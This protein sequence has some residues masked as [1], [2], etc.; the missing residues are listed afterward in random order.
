MPLT[1]S[2]PLQEG[3]PSLRFPGNA[4]SRQSEATR[5][6]GAAPPIAASEHPPSLPSPAGSGRF[7]AALRRLPLNR[8][9]PPEELARPPL[10]AFPPSRPKPWSR[11]DRL[12]PAPPRGQLASTP[13]DKKNFMTFSEPRKQKFHQ[14]FRPFPCGFLAQ[15]PIPNCN[16]TYGSLGHN[17]S[18]TCPQ[19]LEKRPTTPFSRF[20]RER[21]SKSSLDRFGCFKFRFFLPGPLTRNCRFRFQTQ[22]RYETESEKHCGIDIED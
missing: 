14:K 3:R 18:T 21:L 13:W 17:L 5:R 22:L 9:K 10:A 11:T 4:G 20:L 1:T 19:V 8:S 15:N 6:P 16:F 12:R 2:A 7:G